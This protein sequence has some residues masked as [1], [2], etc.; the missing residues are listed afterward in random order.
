MVCQYQTK[1]S[2]DPTTSCYLA[3]PLPSKKRLSKCLRTPPPSSESSS[4]SLRKIFLVSAVLSQ[5]FDREKH[6]YS[7][8]F[9]APL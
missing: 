4:K 6:T 3:S 8:T 5:R 9:R 1:L 7:S 2:R